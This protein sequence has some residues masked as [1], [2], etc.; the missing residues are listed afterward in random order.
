MRKGGAVERAHNDVDLGALRGRRAKAIRDVDV[1]GYELLSEVGDEAYQSVVA[2]MPEA[3]GAARHMVVEMTNEL[4]EVVGVRDGAGG[5]VVGTGVVAV[6]AER[7][8]N[9]GEGDSKPM[10]VQEL[11]VRCRSVRRGA[12]RS[13]L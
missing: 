6:A 13:K 7:R 8:W 9:E 3:A 2:A 5:R 10:A 1:G 12:A 4:G 11:C